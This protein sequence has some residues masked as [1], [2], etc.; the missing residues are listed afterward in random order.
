MNVKTAER[1]RKFVPKKRIEKVE[2]LLIEVG[3]IKQ[4]FENGL[5]SDKFAQ[6]QLTGKIT[7]AI[8]NKIITPENAQEVLEIDNNTVEYLKNKYSV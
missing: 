3:T 4:N 7:E 6:Q 5:V 2:R 1:I 8:Q